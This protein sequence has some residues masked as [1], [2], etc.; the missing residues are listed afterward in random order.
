VGFVAD[1]GADSLLAL[2]PLGRVLMPGCPL[3]LR[4]FEPRYR[5]LLADVG[6]EGGARR[7]GV[8]GLTAGLE[9]AGL[10]AAAPQFARVGTVAEILEVH[11]APDGTVSVLT[12]GSSRFRIIR[13]VETGAPYL[14]A[15]VRFLDEVDG[16]LPDGLIGAARALSAEYARLFGALTGTDQSSRDRYPA[17]AGLLSYRL[18]SEAPLSQDDQ[19]RLLEDDTAVARLLHVQRLLRR[20][21][22]LLRRTRTVAVSPAL[23]RVMLR[24]G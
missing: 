19:Q 7:F 4:I 17:D 16:Q 13:L 20:E 23:L 15:E 8:V 12:A 24:P 5:R 14:M 22:T 10:S 11:P 9:V 1:D 3:P 6:D 18:A 2:F 21:L